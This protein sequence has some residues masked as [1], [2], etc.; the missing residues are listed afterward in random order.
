[1]A[2]I[3][4]EL[5]SKCGISADQAK[6]A[7]GAVL[8]LLK[9]KL[10]AETFNK[11]RDSVPA[12]DNLMAAA[13][14]GEQ[15]GG[16]VVEAVKGAIGKMFGGGDAMAALRAGLGI[17]PPRDR[18]LEG[19]AARERH[20]QDHGVV[21]VPARGGSLAS[22]PPAH[23]SGGRAR[24]A[25]RIPPSKNSHRVGNDVMRTRTTLAAGLLE[26]PRSSFCLQC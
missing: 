7:F 10:P 6:K 19:Q 22:T 23:G 13:D 14:M 16:G 2:D 12:A 5:A 24:F 1:M 4:A 18:V 17:H 21:A 3:A 9:S 15:A 20:E 25:C 26:W 11:L 8:G